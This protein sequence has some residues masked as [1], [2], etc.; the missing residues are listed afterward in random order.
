MDASYILAAGSAMLQMGLFCVI[1]SLFGRFPRPEGLLSQASLKTLSSC[2]YWLFTPA[3]LLTTFGAKLTPETLAS[4]AT[5]RSMGMGIAVYDPVVTHDP[6]FSFVQCFAWSLLHAIVNFIVGA[7]VMGCMV[8]IDPELVAAY[9]LAVTYNNGA[10]VPLLVFAGL[11]RST[12][13][14]RGDTGAYDRSVGLIFAYVLL[15]NFTFW[16]V[17]VAHIERNAARLRAARAAAAAAA[18]T[19]ATAALPDLESADSHSGSPEQRPSGRDRKGPPPLSEQ[20]EAGG[21]GGYDAR[22]LGPAGLVAGSG[23]APAATA[24]SLSVLFAPAAGAAN[25]AD[26][27][28]SVFSRQ[29]WEAALYA[30]GG[31]AW[32]AFRK[33]IITP[34][35]LGIIG[36]VVIGL[37]GPLRSLLFVP[38]GALQPIGDVLALVGQPSVPCSN[39]ILGGSLYHGLADLWRIV[40]VRRA[41]RTGLRRCSDARSGLA[42]SNCGTRTRHFCRTTGDARLSVSA[43]AAAK[44]APSV[45][46]HHRLLMNPERREPRPL[47]RCVL[48]PAH[49]RSPRWQTRMTRATGITPQRRRYTPLG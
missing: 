24:P 19:A 4:A 30:G 22:P 15:W 46:R 39:L 10:S 45:L 36:G 38:G 18:A 26:G 40:Q 3:L 44:V 28:M 21:S 1:G 25:S 12:P 17:G 27:A 16:S 33:A 11:T 41:L 43:P 14:L 9:E 20:S 7:K 6:V 8:P 48:A 5:V 23:A 2:V 34:P 32:R 49:P 47:V 13:Q 42:A 35:V 31:I 29:H 37:S